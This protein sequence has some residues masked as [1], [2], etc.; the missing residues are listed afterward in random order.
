MLMLQR[1]YP[2]GRKM[3]EVFRPLCLVITIYLISVFILSIL[4]PSPNSQSVLLPI[5][6]MESLNSLS[7]LISDS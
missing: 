5:P 6:T 2:V 7:Q 4:R 1:L 3:A